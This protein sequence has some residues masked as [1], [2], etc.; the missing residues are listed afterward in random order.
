MSSI[1]EQYQGSVALQ[2]VQS[3]GWDWKPSSPPNI[4]LETCP[5]CGK[6]NYGHFYMEVH[7]TADEQQNRDGLHQC[8]RCGKGGSLYSLKEHLGVVIPGVQSRK[9]WSGGEKK[10]E[11]L[12]DVDACHQALL[13]DEAALD[14][15]KNGRGFSPEIIER[16]KIG[17]VPKR[18]FREC[19][20]VRAIVYPYLVNGNCIFAHYRTL[21][22]MP[23]AESKVPKA[24]SSP[25]GWDVPLYN[26]EVLLPGL[27][28]IV[29]VEGEANCI[30]AMDKGIENI[31]GVP[32]ANVKKA[33][34][35]DT[36]D[37]LEL[38][39]IYICYD[40]DKVGQRAAQTLAS[41]IGVEKCYKITLPDFTVIT[42]EG[43]RPGKDLNE[44]FAFGGGTAEA[45]EE[46]KKTAVLFDVDGV[47][48]S[49]DAVQELYEQ[50]MGKE[51][52]E[53]PYKSPWASLNKHVGFDIGDVIDILAP[54][55]VGKTTFGLN[56][57]EHMVNTYGEDGIII[58]LEMTTAKLARKWVSHV[59]SV[60]DNVPK[61]PEEAKA[62]KEAFLKAI[63]YAQEKAANRE[64]DLYFCYPK[65]KNVEDIYKLI[66]DCIR[67]YGVKWVMFDNLQRLCDAT[68]GSKNRTQHLSE[69]SK[70]LSQIAKDYNIQM[71]R[72][73]QPHRIAD[74]KMCQSDDV[75]GSSQINKDCDCQIV[76][77]RFRV[78][79]M[80]QDQFQSCGYVET[81]T[82]FDEKMEAKIGLSRYSSGGGT[83]LYYDGA[84]STVTEYDLA[85]IAALKAAANKNVGYE[86][87]EQA[88]G[89]TPVTT[90]ATWTA[91]QGSIPD[92][93]AD[94][95]AITI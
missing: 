47:S 93:P 35:I 81:E 19:G 32:G 1:P 34:W 59:A 26:G 9:D 72:V 52:L 84:R 38:D 64:G 60:E 88:L 7:G 30:A 94:P 55:K 5:Y 23:V 85:Q 17:F 16:Q 27:K 21:P 71:I 58:C 39:K 45:F 28:E 4:E 65:Y 91:I 86:A 25:T 54:E 74:G 77:N 87:Q 33:E 51:G 2:F 41:R 11:P 15:L 18:R 48:S 36:L 8:H 62:L 95:N 14:Y 89:I 75:D 13:E 29:M 82:T 76:L 83:T 73:L 57:I 68:L 42:E 63:P 31:C 12:P 22:T 10:I 40:K 70:V 53:P 50:I 80:T 20:E 67:R 43:E 90:N 56:L 24:F 6:S 69:I 3:R 46:L 49:Q 37:K 78:G 79:E 92:A 61:T 44:W 66:R